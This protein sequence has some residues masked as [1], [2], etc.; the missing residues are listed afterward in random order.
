MFF[1]PTNKE[2]I[3]NIKL[4]LYYTG[5]KKKARIKE[6]EGKWTTVQ[7]NEDCTANLTVTIPANGY[8]WYVIE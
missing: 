3:R 5:L 7:L 6:Q 1:N 8:T 2:I 4:P